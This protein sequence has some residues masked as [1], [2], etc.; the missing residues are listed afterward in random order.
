ML[1]ITAGII[2]IP[3]AVAKTVAAFGIGL[4]AGAVTWLLPGY[5]GAGHHSTVRIGSAYPVSSSAS[6]GRASISAHD[7]TRT[8]A[9][10]T[11]F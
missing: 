3:F 7:P 10:S 2:G 8:P 4:F 6:F 9:S 11:S 1:L 5:A